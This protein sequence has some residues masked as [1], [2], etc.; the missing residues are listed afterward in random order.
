MVVG[1]VFWT[2]SRGLP[3]LDQLERIEP[4]LISI[5]YDKDSIPVYE[6][7][8]QRR[9]WTPYEDIPKPL[10][11]AIT[12]IEDRHFFNH[13]GVHLKSY[14]SALFP[15]LVGGRARGASTL[16]LQLAKLLFFTSERSIKRKVQE[17]MVAVLIEQTYTK[18]EIMEFYVNEVYLGGGSYGFQSASQK[19]FDKPLDSLSFSQ[20][21]L[22]AGLLQR[23]EAYRPD[24]YPERAEKRRNVVLR[25]M[26]KW[27]I[28]SERQLAKSLKDT[29]EVAQKNSRS[30]IGPYF[31]ETIRREI[32]KK[33]GATF[34]YQSGLSVYSTLDQNLQTISDSVFASHIEKI[35]R[36][37]KYRTAEKL[38]MV[39]SL[40][41]PLD[42]I[43]QYWDSTYALY[44][45]QYVRALEQHKSLTDT[46]PTLFPD[47]LRYRK[48]QGALVVLDNAT[49]AVRALVGGQDFTQSKFNR[50][51]QALRSPGSA[52]KAIVY[53]VAL[54]NGATLLDTLEDQP[55]TIPDPS[56]LKKT[57]RPKNYNNKFDGNVS[58]QSSFYQSKNLPS[59]RLG[60]QYGLET[61]VSYARRFGLKHHIPKVPSLG[62]GAGETT[63][64]EMTSAYTTFPNYGV[65]YDPFMLKEITDR[66]NT[67][68]YEYFPQKHVTLPYKTAFY[69]VDL[70]QGVNKYGTARKVRWSGLEHPSGGKTGTTNGAT[71]AWYIGFTKHYTMGV[72]IG[73]DDHKPMG[74]G[75][76]GGSVALPIWIDVMKAANKGL[77]VADFKLPEGLK[78][79]TMCS[80]T[81]QEA[82]PFCSQTFQEYYIEGDAPESACDG[83]HHIHSSPSEKENSEV[84][85][86]STQKPPSQKNES[87]SGVGNRRTF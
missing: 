26:H 37:M 32:E 87:T 45:E 70:L 40:Q 29:V 51:T 8:T 6:F 44:Q 24:R 60:I 46:L 53:S 28:I 22:L 10:I 4:A 77:P 81:K 82:S 47:S 86:F 67:T 31:V 21:A 71:D 3:S 78:K 38:A 56:D 54:D 14:P 42:T 34:L 65:R 49:G 36:R 79:Y 50:A 17:L 66:T 25:A 23:P 9:V 80:V 59:I 64:L 57:W 39:D 43:V 41:L 84:F 83:Q 68:I 69:M 35:Q 74:K 27:D 30:T 73:T 55:I 20:Y 85:D 7:Y 5:V 19:Y 1:G 62:I 58:L 72:W 15:A 11:L 18:E 13:W 33:W 75:H 48:I 63:L 16:T 61:V 52:F 76:T 12:S 2:Y